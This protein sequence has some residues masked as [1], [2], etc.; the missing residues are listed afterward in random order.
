MSER[1]RFYTNKGSRSQLLAIAPETDFSPSKRYNIIEEEDQNLNRNIGDLQEGT[2]AR[3][4]VFQKRIDNIWDDTE[5]WEAKL[6]TEAREA[7]ETITNMRD[8]YQLHM[9]EFTAQL[10][11][12]IKTVFDNI[13]NKLVIDQQERLQKVGDKLSHFVTKTA[14]A[15]IDNTSGEVRR[16]LKKQIETFSIGQQKER[17]R[18]QKF[19]NNASSH[20][21]KTAQQFTDEEALT[22]SCFANLEDDVVQHERRA[23]RMHFYRYICIYIYQHIYMY[24]DVMIIITIILLPYNDG[25]NFTIYSLFP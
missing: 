14:P 25:L 10:Q 22:M 11:S 15:G 12:E 17:I 2:K 24:T 6:K 21:Q 8:E 3:N 5:I 16:G 4:R 18:E 23:V 19:V 1:T 7:V 9:D 20:I 13:D